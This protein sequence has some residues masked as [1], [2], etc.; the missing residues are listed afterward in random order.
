M[1]KPSHGI[2]VTALAVVGASP[3]LDMPTL[4][5]EQST[6]AS[7]TAYADVGFEQAVI[8]PS[9]IAYERAVGDIDGD[10]DNDIIAASIFP[11]NLLWLYRAPDFNRETVLTLNSSTHGWPYFRSDD[12]QLAD[13]DLDGDLDVVTRIGDSGDIN[14]HVVWI[15]NPLV[16][17]NDVGGS[18]DV[19]V[20]GTSEYAKDIVIAD[21]DRDGR[22]DV[23]TR[24]DNQTQIWFNDGPTSWVEK[25]IDHSAHEGM[26]VGDLDGDGDPDIVLNGFWLQTPSDPRTGNYTN[27]NID[28]KWHNQNVGWESNSCKVV[29]ADIDG[30]GAN[31][32]VLSHSEYVG[33]PVSWYSASNPVSGPW[34]EHVIVPVCDDCHNLQAKDFNG[35]GDIDVVYGGMPQSSQRGLH[36]LLGN[37][38]SSW[39]AMEIQNQG[40]YSAEIG[41]FDEDGDW[42]IISVRNWDTQP[43]EIWR[44]ALAEPSPPFPLDQWQYVTIDNDRQLFDNQNAY[45]GLGW[46]DINGDGFVDLVSGK[47]FYR[48]PGGDMS[49]APWPSI[50]FNLGFDLDASLVVDVD[51]D[52][53]G[54]VIASTGPQIY[55]LEADDIRGTS[56]TAYLIDNNAPFEPVHDIPQGYAAADIIPGGQSEILF[57]NGDTLY[58]YQIPSSNPEAGNWPMTILIDECISEDIGIGDIDRDGL[59][60]VAVAYF[61]G[62][63]AKGLKWARNP[64][65]GSGHWQ[66][67]IVGEIVPAGASQYPDRIKIAE[68]NGDTRVDIVCTEEVQSQSASTYWFEAPSDPTQGSWPRH[69]IVTQNTTNSMDVADMDNDGDIDVVTQEHRGTKKLQIWENDGCGDFTERIVDSG[70]EGHLG[71]RVVDLDQDGGNEIVSIAYDD[72]AAMHLWRNDNLTCPSADGDYDND[73]NIDNDDAQQLVGCLSQP[74]VPTSTGGCESFDFDCDLDVDLQDFL[75]FQAI[76]GES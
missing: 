60:D 9:G 55:W 37:G 41:D 44:N 11:D 42:D 46:G 61:E 27:R 2:I 49:A 8:D 73:G 59:I 6:N 56:W 23:V 70:K 30:N 12:L 36:L 39:S 69:T 62:N 29:V 26:D 32:V 65:D 76:R 71:A 63:G 18:W 4:F 58:A 1:K 3:G 5:G 50:D 14:G 53:Y 19:H 48:N 33:Y 72:Y 74:G 22:P 57:N 17:C 25:A 13:L 68:L 64:G 67:Y 31:D 38:G 24:E 47:W 34:T 40:S 45:F 28:S 43:T 7:G 35:D 52:A 66:E 51:N 10:G 16:A 21:I 75:M 15:E 54:D 20:I